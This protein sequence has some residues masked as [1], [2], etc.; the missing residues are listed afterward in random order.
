M[1]LH[2]RTAVARL[3]LRQLGLLVSFSFL[4]SFFCVYITVSDILLCVS[5]LSCGEINVI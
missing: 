4:G 5:A 1:G 3:T 2:A